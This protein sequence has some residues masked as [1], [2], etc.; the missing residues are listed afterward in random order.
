MLIAAAAVLAVNTVITGPQRSLL[1]TGAARR[2]QMCAAA[3]EL[4]VEVGVDE[5]GQTT[6]GS[7]GRLPSSGAVVAGCPARPVDPFK[8]GLMIARGGQR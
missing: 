5:S 1:W 3:N 4:F 7:A 2:R 8:T 6:R